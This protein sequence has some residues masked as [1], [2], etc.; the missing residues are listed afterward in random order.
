[1]VIVVEERDIDCPSVDLS[2]PVNLYQKYFDGPHF[3]ILYADLRAY[4][5]EHKGSVDGREVRRDII[6]RLFETLAYYYD[7][8]HPQEVMSPRET[9][10]HYTDVLYPGYSEYRPNTL[11]G[12]GLPRISV[13][14]GL[15]LNEEGKIECV[16]EYT[17]RRKED[18]FND[19][20]GRN[21]T[22]I[23][24]RPENFSDSCKIVLVTPRRDYQFPVF[25]QRHVEHV[26]LPFNH[27]EFTGFFDRVWS[28]S[29]YPESISIVNMY[30]LA[31]RWA[32]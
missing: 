17:M 12:F 18:K 9:L 8:L 21:T 28:S 30:E 10:E 19:I 29:P 32:A 7:W 5:L 6:G 11:R 13:P 22:S 3:R 2:V 27:R 25:N 14:D 20:V 15:I 4:F 26:C 23:I 1:M 16:A 31:R 24:R